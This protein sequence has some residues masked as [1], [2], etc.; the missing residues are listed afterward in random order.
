M[1]RTSVNILGLEQ[2]TFQLGKTWRERCEEN[3]LSLYNSARF[4]SNGSSNF[5]AVPSNCISRKH[6]LMN[7]PVSIQRG[8]FSSWCSDWCRA[9]GDKS[10]TPRVW[11]VHPRPMEDGYKYEGERILIILSSLLFLSSHRLISMTPDIVCMILLLFKSVGGELFTVVRV[12]YELDA[13]DLVIAIS[14]PFGIRSLMRP[15]SD[16]HH[17]ALTV[18]RLSFLLFWSFLTSSRFSSRMS[19]PPFSK[20]LDSKRCLSFNWPISSSSSKLYW[21]TLLDLHTVYLIWAR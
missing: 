17:D 12:L 20:D 9:T 1:R 7:H 21:A 3:E 14:Y 4:K 18:G 2:R 6:H 5:D 8:V 16:S 13:F 15:F 10:I 19:S 11:F